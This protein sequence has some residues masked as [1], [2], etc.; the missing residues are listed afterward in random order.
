MTM[1]FTPILVTQQEYY[2]I[3][4][5]LFIFCMFYTAKQLFLPPHEREQDDN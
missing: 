3:G 1:L 5:A 2:T 4:F